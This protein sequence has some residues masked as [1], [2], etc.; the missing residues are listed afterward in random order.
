MDVNDN[1]FVTALDALL[2]INAL[3]L[4]FVLT[5]TLPDPFIPVQYLDVNADAVVSPIDALLVI[6]ELN[7]QVAGEGETNSQDTIELIAYDIEDLKLRK[8]NH[9]VIVAPV[10]DG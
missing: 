5:P 8:R 1:G 7:R 6:N 4:R 3:N 2:V 10:S 9:S